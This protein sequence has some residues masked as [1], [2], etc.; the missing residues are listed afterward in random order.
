[1]MRKILLGFLALVFLAGCADL[2]ERTPATSP[3]TT[4]SPETQLV[5]ITSTRTPTITLEP[6]TTATALS[7]PTA[8]ETISPTQPS[9]ETPDYYATETSIVGE[10]LATVT[11]EP[12]EGYN[13][14]DGVWR[15]EVFTHNCTQ[16]VPD[17]WF[18]NAY[19]QLQIVRRDS[20]ETFTAWTQL[21][22]CGGLG[23]FGLG[24]LN[25]SDDSRY[26]YFTDAREGVPDGGFMGGW[27]RTILRVDTTTGETEHLGSGPFS[28]DGDRFAAIAFTPEGGCRPE[29]MTVWDLSGD[30]L[31]RYPI[32][33][34]EDG[35]WYGDVAWSPGEEQLAF[36]EAVCLGNNFPLGGGCD[37]N[38]YRIDIDE[39]EQQL[40]WEGRDPAFLAFVLWDEPG[41]LTLVDNEYQEWYYDLEAGELEGEN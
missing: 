6:T 23:A 30:V 10:I 41:S 37:V 31:I 27:H 35:C 18:E 15:A 1:M 20:Q 3:P 16:I 26:F 4:S 25:W 36:I 2:A 40:L 38:L 8:E 5:D 9:E 28:P 13:S 29:H 12:R 22:Y 21:Q 32:E 11:P 19:D 34:P 24:G 33:V 39:E 17:E 14:P 7:T